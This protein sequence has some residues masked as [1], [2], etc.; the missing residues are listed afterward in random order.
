MH[1]ESSLRHKGGSKERGTE[2]LNGRVGG[3]VGGER[4]RRERERWRG[5]EGFAFKGRSLRR[6]D[7]KEKQTGC[8]G[9]PG[10]NR[11]DEADG[12]R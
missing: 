2:R 6:N 12:R 11:I 8:D 10:C 7:V 1:G 9:S 4:E 5:G 3:Y